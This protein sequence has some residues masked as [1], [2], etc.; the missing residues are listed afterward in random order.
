M[1]LKVTVSEIPT[2]SLVL[3][4]GKYSIYTRI[5]EYITYIGLYTCEL[6]VIFALPAND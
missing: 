6:Y 1:G 4:L 2:L 5:N 3:F